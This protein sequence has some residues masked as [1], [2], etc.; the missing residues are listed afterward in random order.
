[1]SDTK[2]KKPKTVCEYTEKQWDRLSDKKQEQVPTC[3][4]Y[5]CF[6]CYGDRTY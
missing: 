3:G 1:M 4:R 2:K 6:N 5:M